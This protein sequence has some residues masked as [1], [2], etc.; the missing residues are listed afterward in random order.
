MQVNEVMANRTKQ[1]FH[2]SKKARGMDHGNE[3]EANQKRY[4]GN[5]K[6]KQKMNPVIYSL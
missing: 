4:H 6:E 2:L 3:E 1:R 5:R